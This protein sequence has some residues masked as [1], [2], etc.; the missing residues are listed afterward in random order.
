MSGDMKFFIKKILNI[1]T[2]YV[3]TI[4]WNLHIQKI[5]RLDEGLSLSVY[6]YI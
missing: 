6:I 5:F 1:S 2:N 3:K 4:V